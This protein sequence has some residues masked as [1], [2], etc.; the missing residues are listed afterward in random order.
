[1]RQGQAVGGN[2]FHV[3]GTVPLL[4]SQYGIRPPTAMMGT[5]RTRDAV[6]IRFDVTLT[7]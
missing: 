6:T 4:M 3:T 7:R 1:M 5:M 2:R